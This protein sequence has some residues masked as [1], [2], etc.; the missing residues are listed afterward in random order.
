MLLAQLDGRS[1]RTPEAVEDYRRALEADPG[2]A[3]ARSGLLWLLVEARDREALSRWISAWE[4]DA[5]EEPALWRP[6]AAGLELL[7]RREEA[8][9]FHARQVS[10]DPDDAEARARY[11]AAVAAARVPPRPA[12]TLQAELAV[13]SMGPVV[14]RRAE[15]RTSSWIGGAEVDLRAAMADVASGLPVAA[16]DRRALEVR[17][18]AAWEALGGRTELSGGV[19]VKADRIAPLGSVAHARRLAPFAELRV[20]AAANERAPESAELLMAGS[21]HR[22]GGSLTLIAGDAY[23][24]GVAEWT[25]WRWDAGASLGHGGAGTVELGWR[26][27]IPEPEIT[28]RVQGAYH[29]SWLVDGAPGASLLPGELYTV[30][31]GASASRWRVGPA[32]LLADAWL[33]W[34]S[35]PDRPVYRLQAGLAVA[36]F[37]AAQLSLTAYAANDRWGAGAGD[38]GLTASLSYQLPHPSTPREP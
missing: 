20:E 37:G 30:G 6:Y 28:L 33:G 23:G 11:L 29:R 9:A 16:S 17:A 36:P 19:G 2:S 14:L 25:A 31:A 22:A 38:F 32:L 24:R 8:L 5:R 3:V 21:R 15:A 13:Q 27:P 18:G 26:A 12:A 34:I 35:H 1:G 7:G 4:A 10:A